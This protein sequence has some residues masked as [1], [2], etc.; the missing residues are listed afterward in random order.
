V[1][2]LLSGKASVDQLA[3]KFGV[4]GETI[5]KW[6]DEALLGI[7]SA[8]RHGTKTTRER[9]LEQ[10]NQVLRDALTRQTMKAELLERA[11]E[12]RGGPSSPT[13]SRR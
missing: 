9:E 11:L 13:R 6:R 4:K 1:K 10:D 7:E 3:L 8:L 2:A 5:E 12:T